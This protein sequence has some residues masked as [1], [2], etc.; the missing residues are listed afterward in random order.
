MSIDTY[1]VRCDRLEKATLHAGQ[2]AAV[3]TI[4]GGNLSEQRVECYAIC[5]AVRLAEHLATDLDKLTD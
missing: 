2:L 5:A 4:I 3:L 1:T